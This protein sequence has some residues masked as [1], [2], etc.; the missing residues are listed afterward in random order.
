MPYDYYNGYDAPYGYGA[1]YG[2]RQG[3]GSYHDGFR[4]SCCGDNFKRYDPCYFS[5]Y[6]YGRPYNRGCCGW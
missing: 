5:N 2:Y 4:K 3:Y 6:Y 1:V